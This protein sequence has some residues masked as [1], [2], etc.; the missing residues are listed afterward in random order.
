MIQKRLVTPALD[1]IVCLYNKI[2][3]VQFLGAY[4]STM[5]VPFYYA[6]TIL[7]LCLYYVHYICTM[8]TISVLCLHYVYYAYYLCTMS[9]M[10]VPVYYTYL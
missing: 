1:H 5:P 10:P 8:F 6:C 7:V 2:T 3:F 9:T 4:M